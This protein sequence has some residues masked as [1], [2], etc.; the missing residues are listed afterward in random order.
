VCCSWAI[1]HLAVCL[2]KISTLPGCC[3]C[4]SSTHSELF[5]DLSFDSRMLSHWLVSAKVLGDV[6]VACQDIDYQAGW[7][8]GSFV[9]VVIGVHVDRRCID[10]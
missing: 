9:A 7:Q 2:F 6:A 4:A 3:C 10:Y 5:V 8:L 1:F